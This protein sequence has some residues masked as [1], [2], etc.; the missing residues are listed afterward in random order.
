MKKKVLAEYLDE[1]IEDIEEINNIFYCLNGKY[2]IIDT[3]EAHRVL[4]SYINDIIESDKWQIEQDLKTHSLEYILKFIDVSTYYDN[5]H[6]DL[7][8]F[9]WKEIDDVEYGTFYILKL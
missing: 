7:T 4:T 6:F 5:E 9:D 1:D 3:T 2:K 8:D